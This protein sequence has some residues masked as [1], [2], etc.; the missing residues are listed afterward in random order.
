MDHV[1]NI[2]ILGIKHHNIGI[3]VLHSNLRDDC[4]SCSS[5][6]VFVEDDGI[7]EWVNVVVFIVFLLIFLNITFS[8]NNH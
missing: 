8:S 4:V 3:R 2:I 5:L 7:K 1:A 6:I